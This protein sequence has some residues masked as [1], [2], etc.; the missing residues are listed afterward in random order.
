HRARLRR[1]QRRR[2]LRRAEEGRVLVVALH[3]RLLG[4]RPLPHRDL[5]DL[6]GSDTMCGIVGLHLRDRDLYPLL[7]ELLAGMLAEMADR[8][9]APAGIAV[10]GNEAWSPAGLGTI[11]LID[12]D[13]A[14]DDV[15][16][17]L[18]AEIGSEVMVTLVGSVLLASARAEAG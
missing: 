12:I 14:T 16:A 3:G 8:G 1:R 2:L 6:E 7:G 18:G 15:A 13:A 10:Y 4:A 5:S 11:S 9:A 17:A